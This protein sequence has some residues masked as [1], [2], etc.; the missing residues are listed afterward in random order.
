ML[1]SSHS[2]F[3]L[4]SRVS[5]LRNFFVLFPWSASS[6]SSTSRR[7]FKEKRKKP[8]SLPGLVVYWY[9]ARDWGASA[10]EKNAICV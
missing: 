7:S 2:T 8:K 9:Y 3:L 6:S 5:D 4:S 10:S 1:V